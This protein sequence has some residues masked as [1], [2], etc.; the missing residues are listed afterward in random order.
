MQQQQEQQQPS[1]S[2]SNS[3]L[4]FSHSFSADVI[5]A[6]ERFAANICYKEREKRNLLRIV[7]KECQSYKF[8]RVSLPKEISKKKT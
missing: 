8:D 7:F 1:Q 2:V 4:T 5:W 3:C 6:K